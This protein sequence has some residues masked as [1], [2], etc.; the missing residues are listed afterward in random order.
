M[1]RSP[2]FGSAA[3]NFSPSSDSLS[4][5][6]RVSRLTSPA[7][8]NSPVRSTKSTPSHIYRALTACKHTVSGPLSLPSRGA[9]HLSLTVLVHY[10]SPRVFSLGGWSPRIPTGLHVSS[11]TWDP[12]LRLRLFAYKAF[13]FCGGPFQTASTKSSTAYTRVPQP[14]YSEEYWFRLAPFRSPLLGGS[15]FLSLPPATKMFQFAGCPP[16]TYGFSMR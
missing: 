4:L 1:G 8:C 13:T 5:R 15:I 7:G 11:G 2:G 16:H 6:L 12:L 10:R 14:Q 9:F 3:T